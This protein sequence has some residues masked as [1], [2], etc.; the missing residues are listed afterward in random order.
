MTITTSHNEP[1]WIIIT[2][3]DHKSYDAQ[4]LLVDDNQPLLTNNDPDSPR[5]SPISASPPVQSMKWNSTNHND[6]FHHEPIISWTNHF[7][8]NFTNKL[9]FH[10]GFHPENLTNGD[11][12]GPCFTGCRGAGPRELCR[13]HVGV[14][15]GP[16]TGAGSQWPRRQRISVGP[17]ALGAAERWHPLKLLLDG[18]ECVRFDGYEWHWMA[19]MVV[20]NDG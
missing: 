19:K 10:H 7:T 14:V 9:P 4:P 8:V 17:R 11:L 20:I 2:I 18:W 13:R 5:T 3:I 16:E 1:S 6:E 15:G 12:P